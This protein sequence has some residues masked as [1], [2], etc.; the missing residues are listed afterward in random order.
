LP[1]LDRDLAH[2]PAEL[3]ANHAIV[4]LDHALQRLVLPGA[5][6]AAAEQ[7]Q[8]PE[9]AAARGEPR[10]ARGILYHASDNRLVPG[11]G[12]APAAIYVRAMLPAR[13]FRTGAA[14]TLA[15]ALR[16]EYPDLPWSK[17][18]ELCR[19]GKVQVNGALETDAAR[20]L[21]A[22]DA[23]EVQ[24]GARRLTEGVLDDACVVHFDRQVIVVD[25]PAGV[26]SVPF[27]PGDKDTLIDQVRAWLRKRGDGQGAELGAVQR[28][29]KDTTGILVFARTLAAKRE[30]QQ[31]FRAHSIE[32]RYRALVHG[33]GLH[34]RK[35]E[36]DLIRDRGDGLRGSYGHYRRP[37]GPLPSDAQHAITHF[38]PIQTLSGATLI[39]CRLETGRQHQIRIHLSELGHPLIGESVYIRDYRGPRIEAPRPM[40]HAAVLGFTHPG[41]EREMRFEQKPPADFAAVLEQLRVG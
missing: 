21:T 5:R 14:V 35:V 9:R 17:A 37:R 30:L 20:R 28:L 40:L 27:E 39:E 25:K 12:Q 32:R 31:Q 10:R 1:A 11:G 15:A 8:Q 24:P 34:A 13:S 29:D 18:R 19:R 4:E 3:E 22:G 38:A 7:D 26:L 23:V 36:T 2:A 6:V 16:G 41:S 33:T